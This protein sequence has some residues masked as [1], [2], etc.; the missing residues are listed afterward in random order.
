MKLGNTISV[1]LSLLTCFLSSTRPLPLGCSVVRFFD[2]CFPWRPTR[3][4]RRHRHMQRRKV[5]DF[6]LGPLGYC[7]LGSAYIHLKRACDSSHVKTDGDLP[8]ERQ[9][10]SLSYLIKWPFFSGSLPE[11]LLL[12]ARFRSHWRTK[13]RRLSNRTRCA[14][15]CEEVKRATAAYRDTFLF[16]SVTCPLMSLRVFRSRRSHTCKTRTSCYSWESYR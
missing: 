5:S 9:R 2:F 16:A 1:I 13:L 14:E 10:T 3:D 6:S 8:I 7:N 15:A 4:R 12:A 11:A